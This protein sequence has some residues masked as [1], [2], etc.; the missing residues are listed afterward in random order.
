[1]ISS[2][3]K[4]LICAALL[5][6]LGGCAVLTPLRHAVPEDRQQ[7]A[8]MVGDAPFRFW[9]DVPPPNVDDVLQRS[10]T[11]LLERYR[12]M[13]EPPEGLATA[14]IALS[15]GG[16]DGAFGA[17]LMAGWT[18]CGTRPEFQL[19]TGV[20]TGA[21]LAPFV[22]L[23]PDYDDE[24][25]EAF[26]TIDED[27]ILLFTPIKALFGA[28]SLAET[29]PLSKTIERYATQEMLDAIGREQR[30]GRALYIGTT[31]L[32]AERPVSWNIGALANSGRPDRLELFRKIVLAS[33]SIPGAF[34]P[35]LFD[36][37]VDGKRFEELHVDGG[38]TNSVF[39]LPPQLDLSPIRDLGVPHWIDLYVIQNNKLTPDPATVELGIGRIFTKSI[40][41]LIRA[42]SRGDIYREYIAAQNRGYELKLAFIPSDYQPSLG[43]EAGFNS[44]YMTELFELGYAEAQKGYHWRL[45]PPGLDIPG[46]VEAKPTVCVGDGAATP[47]LDAAAVVN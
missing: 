2:A 40:S 38:V 28:L 13:G 7:D 33:A 14:A 42:Q 46:K 6:G 9:G 3:F 22:F 36:V 12:A 18:A 5:A 10:R 43:V 41:A 29:D 32:D 37:E 17:G 1:M 4:P 21:L 26:T 16:W 27:S 35:V 24:M 30:R 34:P 45:A 47:K 25:R 20:S 8:V 11:M 15:G 19:V 44:A 31:N 23:G 39:F